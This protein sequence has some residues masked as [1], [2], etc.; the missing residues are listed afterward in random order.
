LSQCN[1][2]ETDMPRKSIKK[3]SKNTAAKALRRTKKATV[4]ALLRRKAGATIKE[5]MAATGWQAHSV[6]RFLSGTVRKKLGLKLSNIR[7]DDGARRY[8]LK[9]AS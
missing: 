2:K 8:Y 6:R 7:G 1:D 5:L 3:Q 9:A 4:L